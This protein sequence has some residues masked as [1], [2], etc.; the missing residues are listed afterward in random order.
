MKTF[1]NNTNLTNFKFW[2][3]AKT[4]AE[5]LTY[6]ELL[7]IEFHLM[8]LYPDGISETHLNDLFRFEEDFLCE[9]IGE[10]SE[11]VY[12]REY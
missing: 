3:G 10:T 5:K 12:N 8:E 2:S 7:E 4:F 6:N 11:E 1:N 9:L